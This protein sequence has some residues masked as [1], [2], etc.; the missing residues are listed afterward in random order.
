[1]L[2]FSEFSIFAV[3]M[4]QISTPSKSMSCEFDPL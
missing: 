1:V 4:G 2:D 3:K